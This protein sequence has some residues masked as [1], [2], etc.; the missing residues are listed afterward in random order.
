MNRIALI[1]ASALVSAA[2]VF[3]QADNANTQTTQYYSESDK[4]DFQASEIIGSR[5]YASE[6]S[7]NT[8]DTFKE[9]DKEWDDIGEVNNLIVSRDGTVK[10]VVVGVGGFLGIGEKNVALR[11]SELRFLKKSDDEAD[12]YFLVIKSNKQ[13]LENA[14]EYKVAE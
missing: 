2:P 10:A 11:M 12:D 5:I 8:E 14:P 3:A 9:P 7:V 6:A 13:Q 4:T 1:I